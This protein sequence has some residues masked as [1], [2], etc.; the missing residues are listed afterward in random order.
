MEYSHSSRPAFAVPRGP[1]LVLAVIACSMT[2]G[3]QF[4]TYAGRGGAL[5]GLLGAG[6]GAAIGE[7]N[8]NPLAGA[9][10]GSAVGAMTGGAVGESI[11]E[12]DARNQARVEGLRREFA[13]NG[14]S[15]QDV[16]HMSQAGLGDLVIAQQIQAQGLREPILPEQL[17]WLKQQGV[18]D[19]V[20]AAMQAAGGSPI[21]AST[22]VA[23]PPPVIVE[24]YHFGPSWGW[25]LGP[26]CGPG[27]PRHRGRGG[28]SWGVTIG[29]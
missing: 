2:W 11:D 21:A 28:V 19:T 14:L 25:G 16:V 15:V 27:F 26:R 23:A 24:E 9:A 22:S 4:R 18:S 5:G 3:C 7:A 20:M 29:N 13:E 6:V 17:I 1:W 8:D 12:V 10:I